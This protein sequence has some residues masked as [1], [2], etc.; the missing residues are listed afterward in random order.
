MS[1]NQS[2]K[3]NVEFE[4][5][6]Q[7]E[8]YI[9]ELNSLTLDSDE[10]P[11]TGQSLSEVATFIPSK[12]EKKKEAEKPKLKPVEVP[13][14]LPEPILE[15]TTPIILPQESEIP[16]PHLAPETIVLSK[17]M[18][19]FG[20]A[21]ERAINKK[22]QK[23]DEKAAWEKDKVIETVSDKLLQFIDVATLDALVIQPIQQPM[24]SPEPT[25]EKP[26]EPFKH[27]DCQ[28]EPKKA[29]ST[30]I[31]LAGLGASIGFVALILLVSHLIGLF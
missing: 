6:K 10:K 13:T 9:S 12:P 15:Q 26:S 23:I 3:K 20:D 19:S 25:I 5:G 22:F 4:D 2:Q 31:I 21:L 8:D 17:K 18:F 30:K 28:P 14:P 29:S 24:L 7:V 27:V 1:E 11:Q 16:Q